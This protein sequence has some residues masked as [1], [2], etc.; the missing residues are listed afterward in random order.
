MELRP[1]QR[2]AV[3]SIFRYFEQGRP[4]N[5]LVVVPTAGGKS[6]IMATF[7]KETLQRWPDDPSRFLCVAHVRELVK[8]NSDEML[9]IWPEAPVGIYSAG[10]KRRETQ[11]T[12]TF[13]S[14][15]SIYQRA[16][17]FGEIDLV[18]VDEAHLIP[19]KNHAMYGRLFDDLRKSNPHLKIV[20]TTATPYRLD[21][22]R[23]DRGPDAMFHGI[24]HESSM[25]DL[26]EQGYLARPVSAQATAQISTATVGTRGGDFIPG[27]LE[28]V[29]I[30]PA[31]VRAVAEEIAA[32]A[33]GRQGILVFGCGIKHATM[34]RDALCGLGI[35]C[36]CIF[37]DTPLDVRDDLI[38]RFKRRELRAL[39][40]MNVLTTGFNAPH[41]DLIALARPTQ[42]VGLYIQIVGRG[43][44]L[45]PGKEDCRILDFGGNIARHGPLDKPKVKA[46]K[47]PATAQERE[48]T[49]RCDLCEMS[50][51]LSA[52]FCVHCGAE[53]PAALPV[54]ATTASV[55]PLFSTDAPKPIAK[56]V[57]VH[58]VRYS[59]HP[60]RTPEKPPTMR[61]T[62]TCGLTQV[63]EFVCFEHTGFPRRKAEGWWKKHD[64]LVNSA[65]MPKSVDMALEWR[66]ELKK[67]KRILV[68]PNGK[69]FDVL[70]VEFEHEHAE[71]S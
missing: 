48:P 55:L 11:A 16:Q 12:I 27:Q 36:E 42:S 4:G 17:Q 53:F 19:R 54:V 31:T 51:P 66:F 50:S 63:N 21:S 43:T 24:A 60:P 59:K 25:L 34:L 41:V 9:R 30:N 29:A 68:I 2:A 8:Q 3:D 32:N 45:S 13:A 58:G 22:G 62:Y 49:R 10:L 47:G 14:V 64:K 70:D 65:Y 71:A 57:D 67:P 5:P 69:F 28:A 38:A 33:E 52:R 61:V 20:G 15:Q 18:I 37:G 23:L 6:L 1:Y 35:P 44:R 7:F 39:A 46:D 26:I 40:G 56:W